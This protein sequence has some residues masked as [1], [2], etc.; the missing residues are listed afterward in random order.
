MSDIT[1]TVQIGGNVTIY[2]TDDDGNREY[3]TKGVENHFTN[4]MLRGLTSFM[5]GGQYYGNCML[6]GTLYL[7]SY[8]WNI[9]L[10]LDTVTPT[11]FSMTSL[12]SQLGVSPHTKGDDNIETIDNKCRILYTASWNP[13]TISGRIG[14]IGLYLRAFES[15]S[16]SWVAYHDCN[17]KSNGYS[18]KLCS[19]LSVA[20]GSFNAFEVDTSRALTVVWEVGGSY[21]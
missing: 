4:N 14:E 9:L 13:N 19:R 7:W 20:D 10:G 1:D 18:L 11:T 17:R 3:I 12:V 21:V 15:I 8:D 6:A 16:P 5:C 2:Q